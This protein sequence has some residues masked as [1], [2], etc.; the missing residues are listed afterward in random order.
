MHQY[1]ANRFILGLDSQ[2]LASTTTRSDDTARATA[3]KAIRTY[4]AALDASLRAEAVFNEAATVLDPD[5]S[6]WIATKLCRLETRYA[7][8][9]AKVRRTRGKALVAMEAIGVTVGVG[10]VELDGRIY[11]PTIGDRVFGPDIVSTVCEV[12]RLG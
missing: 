10:L 4:Q 8:S 1:L 2:D 12:H 6:S 9:L 11:C 3:A 5:W 7:R